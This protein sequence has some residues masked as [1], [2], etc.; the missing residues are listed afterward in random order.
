MKGKV[1]VRFSMPN[2]QRFRSRVE[3][4]SAE[5]TKQVRDALAGV[6]CEVLNGHQLEIRAKFIEK[7]N[8]LGLKYKTPQHE[9]KVKSVVEPF[10]DTIFAETP[11]K[12][13]AIVGAEDPDVDTDGAE[14]AADEPTNADEE[15]A[16][17]DSAASS[18]DSFE[19]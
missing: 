7:V 8:A 5:L 17:K 18:D 19:D 4:P 3:K 11:E 15:D 16:S 14:D 13:D 12:L 2:I 9:L 10:F 6:M 1:S